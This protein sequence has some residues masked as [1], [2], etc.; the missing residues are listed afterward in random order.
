MRFIHSVH[1]GLAG[2]PLQQKAIHS[3]CMEKI[4]SR[5][6]LERAAI[7]RGDKQPRLSPRTNANRLSFISHRETAAAFN[8]LRSPKLGRALDLSRELARSLE[9]YRRNNTKTRYPSGDPLHFLLAR[10]LVEVGV[11]IVHFN[12]GYWNWHGDN[13]T[14]GK[15]GG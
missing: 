11:P 10:R 1:P 2:R 6:C 3:H 4:P 8:P 9:R 7:P 15:Q 12:F 14:A 13:F 5:N